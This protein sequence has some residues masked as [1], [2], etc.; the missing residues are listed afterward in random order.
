MNSSTAVSASAVSPPRLLLIL[1]LATFLNYYD[2]ALPAV[3]MEPIRVEFGLSDTWLGLINAAFTVTYALFG[4]LLGRLADTGVRKKVIGYGLIAWSAA[5]ALSGSAAGLG[6]FLLARVGVGIGEASCA[7]TAQSMIADLYPAQRRSRAIGLVMLGLPLGLVAAFLSGGAIAT[8]LGS[9]RAVFWLAAVPGA[10]LGLVMLLLPEP[11]RQAQQEDALAAG[12]GTALRQVWAVPS[13]RWL[14]LG[15]I[16]FGLAGYVGTGFMVALLQRHFQLPLV[17][18]G[19]VSGAI[20][21]GSGLVAMVG[22]GWLADAL[23]QRWKTGRLGL[24][25]VASGAGAVLTLIALRLPATQVGWFVA[26]FAIGWLATY[27]F[28]VCGYPALQEVVASR[29]RAIAMAVNLCIGNIVGG[30]CGVVLVGA[31]SDRFALASA[32]AAGQALDDFHRGA[33]LA[34][35]MLLIPAAMA[36]MALAT[37]RAAHHFVADQQRV[38]PTL[39]AVERAASR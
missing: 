35:A 17:Q 30:G 12:M 32:Q 37:W 28:T 39:S 25:T 27:L 23:Q 24:A 18:A 29:Q 31:L 36:I 6:G 2:R 33:G 19:V 20:I 7:P 14:T 3:L 16:G 26:L 22:G 38:Q 1:F 9:W 15:A 5:T 13:M 10:L 11:P 34:S 4:I 21:G 8:A